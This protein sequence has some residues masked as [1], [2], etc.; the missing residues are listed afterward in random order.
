MLEEA[1]K[2]VNVKVTRK[3]FEGVTHGFYDA[4]AVLPAGK[5]AQALAA[6][7]LKEAFKQ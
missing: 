6:D 3:E 5:K 4:A 2:Q 1:L 7:Q